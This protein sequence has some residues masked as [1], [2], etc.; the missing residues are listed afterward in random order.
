[1]A[2]HPKNSAAIELVNFIRGRVYYRLKTSN[3]F[4]LGLLWGKNLFQVVTKC[5]NNYHFLKNM[6]PLQTLTSKT[7]ACK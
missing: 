1:M 6:S 5:A 4:C 7:P 2:K 3:V